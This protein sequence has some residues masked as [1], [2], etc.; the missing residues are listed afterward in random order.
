MQSAMQQ[1]ILSVPSASRIVSGNSGAIPNR[2]FDRAAFFLNVTSIS[3]GD[4]TLSIEVQDPL[5]SAWLPV[6]TGA[7]INATGSAL[8]QVGL[9]NA[10]VANVSTGKDL[11]LNYRVVWTVTASTLVFSVG[12]V[13]K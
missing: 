7:V 2:G 5:S 11:M 8:Y 9:G 6:L 3:G 10:E 4:L 13:S 12:I 1:N